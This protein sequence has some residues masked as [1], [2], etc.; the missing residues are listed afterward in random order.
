MAIYGFLV[1]FDLFFVE[2]DLVVKIFFEFLKLFLLLESKEMLAE[3]NLV[4][5]LRNLI[6]LHF[7]KP[8]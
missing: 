2:T 7:I 1:A 3:Y 5:L 6:Q 8:G 4:K